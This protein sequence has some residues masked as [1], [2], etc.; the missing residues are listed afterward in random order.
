MR[1]FFANISIGLLIILFPITS[2]SQEG[3]DW[4]YWEPYN[5]AY[6]YKKNNNFKKSAKWY[7]K[8]F[9]YSKEKSISL[10]KLEAAE[11]FAELQNEEKTKRYLSEALPNIH[12]LTVFD[13][14]NKYPAF[15][16]Y[17]NTDWWSEI[18]NE[19]DTKI[20]ELK[21]H[22][23]S[24]KIFKKDSTISYRAMRINNVGDTLANT[25]IH[26][27]FEGVLYMNNSRY[28]NASQAII[29]YD[30]T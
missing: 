18:E 14:K 19:L 29:K 6:Y 22:H 30:F 27:T 23:K 17:R 2:L 10:H 1:T 11:V 8:A 26:L 16:R 20:Q 9:E 7:E 15:D 21:K 12:P 4:N 28:A 3:Y 25:L 5:Q 13:L 24:L